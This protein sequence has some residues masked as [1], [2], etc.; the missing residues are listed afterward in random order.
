MKKSRN[1]W[2]DH[3]FDHLRKK[4]ARRCITMPEWLISIFVLLG[5]TA[6]GL[7]VLYIILKMVKN[8]FFK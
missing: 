5:F 6:L 2:F 7:G 4:A 8:I 3:M 1:E